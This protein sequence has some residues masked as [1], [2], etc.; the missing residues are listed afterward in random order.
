MKLVPTNLLNEIRAN[1]TTLATCIEIRRTDGRTYRLTNHDQTLM[2]EGNSYTHK[3]PFTL[4]GITSGSNLSSNDTEFS[5]YLDGTTFSKDDFDAGLFAGAGVTIMLVNFENTSQ[6]KIVLREGWFG[7]IDTNTYGVAK[8]TIYGLLKV[9]DIEIGRIYQPSCDADL[10]DKRCRVAIKQNQVYSDLEVY[11]TGDWVYHFNTAEATP[12]TVVNGSFEDSA[13]NDGTAPI[14]GWTRS[15]D[16]SM[17]VV[18]NVSLF[19]AFDGTYFLYG[20]PTEPGRTTERFIYQDIDLVA[21]GINA[22]D[23]D[24]GEISVAVFGNLAHTVYLLDYIRLRVEIL[25]SAGVVIDYLDD[26][27]QALDQF[28][29]WRERCLVGPL[30]EGARTL[31]IYI[32]VVI[33][34]GVVFN[35]CADNIRAYWWNHTA[36]S[37]YAEVIHQVSRIARFDESTRRNAENSSFATAAVA[38]SN[39]TPIPG[40]TRGSSADW[41]K[42]E[43]FT[44]MGINPPDGN[45]LLVGGDDSSGVQKTYQIGQTKHLVNDFDLDAGDID[46]GRMVGKLLFSVVYYDTECAARVEVKFL[47]AADV[48]LTTHIP[49]DYAPKAAPTTDNIELIFVIPALARKASITLFAKSGAA[50]SS[51]NI[52]FDHF[53]WH[54]IDGVQ[55]QK[56][57]PVASDGEGVAFST[58]AGAFT[59]D[60]PLIWRAHTSHLAYDTVSSVVDRKTFNGTTISGGAGTFSTAVIRWISGE[61]A[62]QRNLIRLWNPDTK[63]IK[64]YFPTTKPIQVGDRYQYIRPCHKRFLEDCSLTFNNVLNFRGFPHLPGKLS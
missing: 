23:I 27:Y 36:S 51:A 39:V 42:T 48:V 4:S 46:L 14:P 64:L 58:T 16:N 3:L 63:G 53:R 9:L 21:D 57:D 45:S 28:D 8:V 32:Y 20:G 10:G 30:I 22:A 11:R 24:N 35:N 50:F 17:T 7:P 5:V 2:V 60:G 47:D 56:N 62:G 19:G 49:V 31:R 29:E 18:E 44:Y 61:N 13:P 15:P 1:V 12:L 26:G 38:N 55:P 33:H 40:W 6:G 43:S 54:F 37:P 34:E 41:W 59:V 25:N 52:G